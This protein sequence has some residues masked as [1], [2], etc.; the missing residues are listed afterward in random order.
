MTSLK[1]GSSLFSSAPLSFNRFFQRT[2]ERSVQTGIKPWNSFFSFTFTL[3]FDKLFQRLFG[4]SRII[5]KLLDHFFQPLAQLSVMSR[6]F[7]EVK[8]DMIPKGMFH[9]RSPG[10]STWFLFDLFKKSDIGDCHWIN[11]W[12]DAL[13]TYSSINRFIRRSMPSRLS[14]LSR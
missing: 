8:P 14:W 5:F 13:Q 10:T 9:L 2:E 6:V 12:V 3:F 1:A 7:I 4:A 11:A